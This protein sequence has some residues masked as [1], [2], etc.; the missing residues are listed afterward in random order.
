MEYA[1]KVIEVIKSNNNFLQ[2]ISIQTMMKQIF[3][4]LHTQLR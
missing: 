1:Q 3:E 4:N 2:S